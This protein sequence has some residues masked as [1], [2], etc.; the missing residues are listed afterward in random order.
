M[1]TAAARAAAEPANVRTVSRA[2]SGAERDAHR[3]ADAAVRGTPF[4][5]WSFGTVPL[6]SAAAGPSLDT[7]LDTA[8]QAL[9]P[10]LS[11]RFG[12][13]LGTDLSD[14]RVHPDDHDLT[15]RAGADAV[16]VGA[17]IAFAPGLFDPHS[18]S[19]L[20]RVAHELAHVAQHHHG[21]EP[22]AH[23]DG[24]GPVTPATTLGGLPEADRKKISRSRRPRSP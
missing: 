19:G 18:T 21:A 11:A 24:T 14:V 7:S 4:A 15:T 9:D 23:R 13:Q 20:R 8:G 12:A 16:T 3:F 1:N 6:H 22:L 17:E 5:G 2:D 10:R